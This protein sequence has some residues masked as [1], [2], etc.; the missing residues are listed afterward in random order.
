[1]ASLLGSEKAS[2]KRF[3]ITGMFSGGVGS[4]GEW[5]P[6]SG[7]R[8]G[9]DWEAKER[10]LANAPQ[11]TMTQRLAA[12][13]DKANLGAEKPN[14][15][16]EIPKK[17]SVLDKVKAQVKDQAAAKAKSTTKSILNSRAASETDRLDNLFTG[18][19]SHPAQLIPA[20][21]LAGGIAGLVKQVIK[22]KKE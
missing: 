8:Y 2:E 12:A 6:K 20:A 3:K 14:V 9:E 21:R 1:M 18:G 10:Y 19:I 4:S 15:T 5:N 17:Q 13:K 16:V 11:P 22:K 7:S